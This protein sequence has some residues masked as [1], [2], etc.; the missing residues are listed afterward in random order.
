ML[1]PLRLSRSRL[2]TEASQPATEPKVEFVDHLAGVPDALQRLWTPYRMAYIEGE[3]KPKSTQP[4]DCPFC[5][6]PARDD[7][8]SLIVRRGTHTFAVLNLYPYN[9]GHLLVCP[10]RHV[11]G[12]VETTEAESA[13]IA[14]LTKQAIT[15]IKKVSAPEGFNIGMNQ[16]A[17]AGAGITAHLHQHVVPR[18]QGDS[19]F[20]PIVA[21]TKAIPQLLS[22]TRKLLADAWAKE[23]G[24]IVKDHHA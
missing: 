6:A 16:G 8:T 3:D 18:W 17:V 12:Y 7:E 13:E 9:P 2:V 21:R 20:L 10:Y 1:S 19:N 23:Y 15:V 22:Q 24:P 5:Y 14:S 4:A 11:S